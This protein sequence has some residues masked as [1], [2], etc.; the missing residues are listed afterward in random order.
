MFKLYFKKLFLII[1]FTIFVL[2]VYYVCSPMLITISN[3]F[4]HPAIR[5]TILVGVPIFCVLMFVNKRRIE[6]QSLRID[7]VKYI[8]SLSTTN[9]K[10]NIKNE[11]NYLKSFMPLRAEAMAFSTLILPFVMG[12]GLTVENDASVLVN[13]I[14][15]LIVFSLI[16]CIYLQKM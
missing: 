15:G 9:L 13:C 1:L 11:I 8:K 5:Y 4:E 16:I 3:F 10:F 12:I 2:G 14:A 7:Y 6:N